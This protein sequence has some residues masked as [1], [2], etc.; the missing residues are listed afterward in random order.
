MG[1]GDSKL[2]CRDIPHVSGQDNSQTSPPSTH[3]HGSEPE[4]A[5]LGIS[6]PSLC[7][8]LHA[9]IVTATGSARRYRDP[10][11]THIAPPDL[12]IGDNHY[13]QL[14]PCF[15]RQLQ[16]RPNLLSSKAQQQP[17]DLANRTICNYCGRVIL[18]PSRTFR[19]NV[20]MA[21]AYQTSPP[22]EGYSED[23][24]TIRS[25]AILPSW[26]LSMSV[27]ERTGKRDCS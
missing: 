14:V 2:N 12:A 5:H 1:D 16:P 25:S 26:M 9:L 7:S 21:E 11:H 24:L 6:A 23:P 19:S 18:Y 8:I 4:P 22:D 10:T 15:G 13:Q 20:S 27:Q 17:H 3:T